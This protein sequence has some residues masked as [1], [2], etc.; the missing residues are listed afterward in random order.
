VVAGLELAFGL[1]DL[2]ATGLAE[3]E[4]VGLGET[5]GDGLTSATLGMG[6]GEAKLA[7]YLPLNQT[8]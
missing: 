4:A 6:V 1:A 5:I 2:V 3:A 8:K 7:E